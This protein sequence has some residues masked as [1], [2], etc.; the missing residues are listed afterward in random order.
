VARPISANLS[1]CREE[2]QAVW[3]QGAEET[4]ET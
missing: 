2:E 4:P 3:H 1:P